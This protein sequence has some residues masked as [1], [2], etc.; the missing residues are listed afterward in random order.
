MEDIYNLN[1]FLEAQEKDFSVAVQELKNAKKVNHWIWYIFPQIVDLGRSAIDRKFSIKSKAEVK[2][3]YNH[4]IL[5][6][7]LLEVCDILLCLENKSV[8]SIFGHP[9][10]LKV[11]SSISL[12]HIII[13][14]ETVFTAVLEKYFSD[15]IDDKTLSILSTL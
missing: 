14:D 15:R 10:Y 6:K 7:R 1:R 4:P 9:D 12:F 11:W 2:A 13:K 5:G 3:Y 8:I